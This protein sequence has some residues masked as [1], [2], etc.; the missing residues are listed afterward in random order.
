MLKKE[1]MTILGSCLQKAEDEEMVFVLL[2]R[3][4]CASMAVDMWCDLRVA[5]GKNKETD[6][7]ILEARDAARQM[8][9]QYRARIL[10]KASRS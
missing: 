2:A 5:C 3:D 4:P 10:G 9:A 7:E 8:R 1:E 6:Q